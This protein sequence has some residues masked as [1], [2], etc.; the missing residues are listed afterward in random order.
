MKYIAIV[1]LLVLA[2]AGSLVAQTAKPGGQAREAALGGSQAGAGLVLNP[3]IIDDP[4]MMFLNPAYQ[5]NYHDYGWS[6]IAGGNLAG[7]TGT[8][9]DGY[10]LQNAGIAFSLNSDWNLGAILSYDPSAANFVSAS[11]GASSVIR[12]PAQ[13]IPPIQNVMEL[14][15]STH[16]GM[17]TLGF[18]V[19]YGSSKSDLTANTVTPAVS[20]ESDEASSHLWGFR[21]GMIDDLGGG[22]SLDGSAVLR[23]DKAT[24]NE[25]GSPAATFANGD[26]SASGTEFQLMLRGKFKAS[27]KFNFVP[28]AEFLSLSAEP[29]EDTKPNAFANTVTTSDKFSATQYAVGVGGEYRNQGFYIAGGLSWLSAQAKLEH[30]DSQTPANAFTQTYTYSALPV[31]NLGAEWSFLDWLTGRIGY[32]RYNGNVNSKNEQTAG[33]VETNNTAGQFIN[34]GGLGGFFLPGVTSNL[35]TG[36]LNGGTWDGVVTL[37]VGLKWGGWAMD[38]TVSD[39]ALRRGLGLIGGGSDNINTFGYVTASY[40]FSE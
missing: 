22:S 3:F 11:I 35:T 36:N 5:A 26:Y 6:N 7:S 32:F 14:V 25:D 29:K 21:A 12:R 39:E 30:G 34:L 23:L 15:A 8:N 38:A 18:G 13:N 28:Y 17:L 24:D 37:G 31:I 9:Q 1:S 19:M 40:N 10:G 2:I 20:S 33:T 27:S 16:T 4:S